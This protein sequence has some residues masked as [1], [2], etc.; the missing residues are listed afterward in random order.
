MEV[1]MAEDAQLSDIARIEQSEQFLVRQFAFYLNEHQHPGNRL[2]HMF[3]IPLLVVTLVWAIVA[4]S[5]KIFVV[6]Q[7]VG[8]ALQLIGHRIEGNRPALLKRPISF[9]MGPLMV[10]VELGE[11]LGIHPKFAN[12]ARALVG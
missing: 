1:G 12:E 8:W 6:G 3:G 2:T 5:W 11:Y 9:A 4:M 7:V 10:L